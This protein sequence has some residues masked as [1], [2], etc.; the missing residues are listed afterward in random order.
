MKPISN[1]VTDHI[2][3]IR[4]DVKHIIN[5]LENCI[6]EHDSSKFRT[7]APS[8]RLEQV[9]RDEIIQIGESIVTRIIEIED[10]LNHNSWKEHIAPTKQNSVNLYDYVLDLEQRSAPYD[11]VLFECV[12][13]LSKSIDALERFVKIQNVG[14]KAKTSKR[15]Y[16]EHQVKSAIK[17]SEKTKKETRLKMYNKLDRD[18]K[19]LSDNIK[20]SKHEVLCKVVAKLLDLCG[21]DTE[22]YDPELGAN[23]D[24]LAT[25]SYGEI[26]CI[27]ENTTG[28]ISKTKVDKLVGRKTEYEEEYRSWKHLRVYSCIVCNNDRIFADDLAERE[29]GLNH[30]SVLAKKEL[31][32]LVENVKKR[33]MS[34]D[35][36]VERLKKK[37]PK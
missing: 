35:L 33:K 26:V 11:V 32:E 2:A 8:L 3:T 30:I 5:V 29:C 21:F 20:S 16:S 22:I 4:Q 1:I 18:L 28:P 25:D 12:R 23:I 17:G 15:R 31:A 27:F 6:P 37:V 13:K 36:F 24:V 7:T 14:Y 10:E 19:K 34:S 9:E